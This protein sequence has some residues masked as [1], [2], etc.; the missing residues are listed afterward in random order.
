MIVNFVTLKINTIIKWEYPGTWTEWFE[1]PFWKR[2]G[3]RVT[4]HREDDDVQQCGK[5]LVAHCA[6]A[7]MSQVLVK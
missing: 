1:K 3:P 2:S 7:P 5:L 6:E 4:L